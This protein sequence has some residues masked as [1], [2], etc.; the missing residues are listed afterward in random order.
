MF[1]KS[2]R[3]LKNTYIICNIHKIYNI[4]NW[5]NDIT[6]NIKS[7]KYLLKK[8]LNRNLPRYYFRQKLDFMHGMV[9]HVSRLITSRDYLHLYR[10]CSP[11]NRNSLRYSSTLA[12]IIDPTIS[13]E[14][15]S[16][17]PEVVNIEKKIIYE[18]TVPYFL[19]KYNLDTITV[20]GLFFGSRGTI[21][22]FFVNWCKK[23]K[24]QRKVKDEIIKNSVA[25]LRNH[26]QYMQLKK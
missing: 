6:I 17:Q 1:V 18:S 21:F 5:H 20:T 15:S 3:D 13:F 26:L 12:E 11:Q 24:I 25:V 8:R 19:T 7:F 2:W 10:K 4:I 22:K 16:N 9:Q 14:V 23:Y